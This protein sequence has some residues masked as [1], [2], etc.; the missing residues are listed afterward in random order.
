MAGGQKENE[1][2]IV[3]VAFTE[4]ACGSKNGS[5]ARACFFVSFLV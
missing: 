2:E 4:L 1:Y 3:S 5:V